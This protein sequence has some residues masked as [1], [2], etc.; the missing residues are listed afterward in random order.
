[1]D[2]IIP[3]PE[4]DERPSAESTLPGT[5]SD[6]AIVALY[7][8]R[9]ERALEESRKK[10]GGWCLAAAENILSSREDAEECV[11]DA[12][13]RAWR[14]IP[15][16]KPAY[17]GAFLASVTRRLALDRYRAETADKRGGGEVRLCLDELAEIAGSSE[18]WEP[19]TRAGLRDALNRW[20]GAQSPPARRIFLLRYWYAYS[21]RDAAR[22]AGTSVGAAKMSLGRSKKRLRAFLEKEGFTV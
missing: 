21:L 17:L 1:M 19:E 6:A 15:P 14:S 12:L 2:D 18:E 7:W 3:F 22:L 11:N 8:M 9:D 13:F 20:L 16:D 10:Y 4:T 5:P